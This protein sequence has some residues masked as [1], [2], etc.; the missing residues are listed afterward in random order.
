[1]LNAY[2]QD[3]IEEEVL[4]SLQIYYHKTS[5][6]LETLENE[7]LIFMDSLVPQIAGSSAEMKF[8][9]PLINIDVPHMDMPTYESVKSAWGKNPDVTGFVIDGRSLTPTIYYDEQ[10]QELH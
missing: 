8:N 7:A 6:S 1:M 2:A 3:D 4:D 9:Y 10:F 5:K